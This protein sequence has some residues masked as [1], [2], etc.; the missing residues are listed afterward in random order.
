MDTRDQI[1]PDLP[2]LKGG[3]PLFGIFFLSLGRQRGVTCLREAAS[4]KAGGRFSEEYVFSIM[5]SLVTIC[6]EKGLI[7]KEMFGV[8]GVKLSLNASKDG[9][10]K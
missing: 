9:A 3:I 2:L 5:G 1:P 10:G 4:A 8:D 6:D 7:G